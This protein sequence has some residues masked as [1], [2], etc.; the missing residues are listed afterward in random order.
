[1][2]HPLTLLRPGWLLWLLASTSLPL[3]AQTVVCHVNYGGED[4]AVIA[5]PVD[6]PYGVKG[7]E[8]GS[9][10]IFRVVNQTRPTD[11][12]SVKVY[13][14]TNHDDAPALIHQANYSPA[15]VAQ[16]PAKGAAHGFTGLHHVYEPV[17]D[18]EL[19][20]WCEKH[21]ASPQGQP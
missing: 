13:T 2:T 12:A 18:G 17:R 15:Q 20:Y 21:T 4:R 19:Q 14:Y 11:L 10:F 9:Y 3:A 7:V 1:M 6:S 8:V 5:S 16:R